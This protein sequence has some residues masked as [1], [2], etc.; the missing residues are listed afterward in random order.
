MYVLPRDNKLKSKHPNEKEN[1]DKNLNIKS[2][3]TTH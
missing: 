3:L 1:P 2:D